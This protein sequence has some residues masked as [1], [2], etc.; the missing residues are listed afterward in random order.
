MAAITLHPVL[1]L[2][3]NRGIYLPKTFAEEIINGVY[4]VKNM[5]AE[6]RSYLAELGN[7]DNEFY[8]EAWDGLLS[9]CILIDHKGNEYFLYQNDDLWAVPQDMDENEMQE[10]LTQYITIKK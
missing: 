5:N 4:K 8:W 1:L 9:E 10:F 2:D 3:G 6:I 7:P